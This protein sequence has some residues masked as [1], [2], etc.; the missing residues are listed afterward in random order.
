MRGSIVF[1]AALMA[2][3][4][5]A[6]AA[7][8]E[9][10]TV[11]AITD[12][13]DWLSTGL[14]LSAAKTYDFTVND[15]TTTWSA[16]ATDAR[17][18]TANGIGAAAGFGQWTMDGFTANYGALVGDVGG[19]LFLIGTGPTTLTGYSGLLTVGY[20]DSNY[21]DNSGSQSLTISA[22]PESATWAMMLLGVGLIGGGLRISRR[23]D[24]AVAATRQSS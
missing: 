3:S 24:G 4:T 22:I 13:P 12:F 10:V 2:A 5:L 7:A 1:A 18:S 15:P 21:G 8:A 11:Q 19:H 16:G 23:N 9:T 20:W 14:T 6:T 17:T